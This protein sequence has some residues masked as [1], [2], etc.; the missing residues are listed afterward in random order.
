[1]IVEVGGSGGM[2]AVTWIYIWELSYSIQE[3]KVRGKETR[4][5]IIG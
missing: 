2:E 3:D 4:E 1:M 5:K